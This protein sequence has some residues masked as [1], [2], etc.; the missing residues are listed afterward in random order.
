MV[1]YDRK[2][3]KQTGSGHFALVG[4]YHPKRDLLLMLDTAAFKYPPHWAPL[5]AIYNGMCSLDVVT[6]RPRGYMLMT[7]A[8]HSRNGTLVFSHSHDN[9]AANLDERDSSPQNHHFLST[10]LNHVAPHVNQLVN[11]LRLFCLA[12]ASY[13][14]GIFFTFCRA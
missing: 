9:S 1:S 5:T 12:D 10:S 11:K 13:Q 4:G 14:V 3:L 7:K 6:G 2:A 8:F